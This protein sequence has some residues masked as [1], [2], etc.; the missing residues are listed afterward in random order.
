[1]NPGTF[2]NGNIPPSVLLCA[3]LVSVARVLRSGL[4]LRGRGPGRLCLEKQ[5][6]VPGGH[7]E[8]AALVSHALKCRRERLNVGAPVSTPAMCDSSKM[9][10]RVVALLKKKLLTEIIHQQLNLSLEGE[11]LIQLRLSFPS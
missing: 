3:S 7:S 10:P 8:T 6:A 5:T 9:H 1:M 2:S 11:R 4:L